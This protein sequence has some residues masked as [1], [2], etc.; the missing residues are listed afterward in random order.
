MTTTL[1]T[2]LPLPV[3][4]A[5]T[6]GSIVLFLS[7]FRRERA[8]LGPV[9][10]WTIPA[11]RVVL[12]LLVWF[13]IAQPKAVTTREETLPVTTRLG[14]DVS[15][16]MSLVDQF[17]EHT[18]RWQED[19]EI[20][21]L[22][23]ATALT[24]AAKVRLHLQLRRDQADPKA[25]DKANE[26][27]RELLDRVAKA[28]G[29]I[30][31]TGDLD[32]LVQP[33]LDAVL[34]ASEALDKPGE[35]DRIEVLGQVASL[36]SQAASGLRRVAQVLPKT[37]IASGTPQSRIDLVNR[38]MT[39]A[40]PLFDDLADSGEVE[41]F[42]FASTLARTGAEEPFTS[43]DALGE[44]THLYRNLNRMAEEDRV[45]D[46]QLS[47][48]VTDGMDSTPPE[49]W[50][51]SAA[52]RE[53]PLLVLPVGDP[54]TAPDVFIESVVSPARV[55]EEDTFVARV[56]LGTRHLGRETVSVSLVDGGTV[57]DQRELNLE[58]DD[59]A[60]VLDLEWTA[61]GL[62]A[63]DLRIEISSVEGEVIL[64]NNQW[65]A[66]CQVTRDQYRVL[67]CDG[68]PRWETRYL[69][70][71]F[72]RDASI[73]MESLVFAPRHAYPGKPLPPMPALP[74]ALE[75]WQQFDLVILGDVQPRQLTPEHQALLVDYVDGGGNL[76]ILAG[77]DAMPSAYVDTPIE[78]LLPMTRT[79]ATALDGIFVIQPPEDRSLD[80]MVQLAEEN[81]QPVWRTLFSITPQFRLSAWA[82]AKESARSLLVAVDQQSGAT[83]DF[84]ALQRFGRGRVAF[85][86]A[87]CLYHLRSN[88]GDRYHARFWGQMIRGI[89]ADNFGFEGGLIQTRLD[90]SLWGVGAEIQGRVRLTT[91]GGLPMTDADF[92]ALL[93]DG[94]GVAVA[95]MRPIPDPDRPGDY[96]VRFPDARPGQYRIE[97]EGGLLDPLLESDRDSHPNDSAR[98]L[99]VTRES[100][101]RESQP[102]AEPSPFWNRVN[103]LPLATTVTPRTL[104]LV[105]EALGLEPEPVTH[106]T[107]RPLWNTWWCFLAIILVSGTEWL[108]RRTNGLC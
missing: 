39:E 22:E 14:V 95:Q 76:L 69:Q 89:C 8:S 88:Y 71:L 103:E 48:L 27:T 23:E 72:K 53:Q 7:L 49:T 45:G 13:L 96:F 82:R 101:G 19:A 86:A 94:E 24:E 81:G 28:I 5:G 37:E 79:Q 34:R 64:A 17:G 66:P 30:E 12:C 32:R 107:K 99:T 80:P 58:G 47:L 9:V 90:R 44:T 36:V 1:E 40:T 33:P 25:R 35:S 43:G 100:F 83:H 18:N 84:L 29:K 42:S 91:P 105:I 60:Q 51:L 75:L 87:P 68:K 15:A 56:E 63:R 11:L 4:I 16:S 104:P 20:L 59:Q 46:R 92:S 41:I 54:S 21:P 78:P 102:S 2:T 57:L 38:W 3:L 55:R 65:P 50:T 52:V 93:I 77:D 98:K 73:E 70:N 62:G 106:T 67:V 85:A 31:S 97:Y 108:L 26:E 10:R 61:E 6:V 74:L